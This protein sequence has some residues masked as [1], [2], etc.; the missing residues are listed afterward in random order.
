MIIT[1]VCPKNQGKSR[2]NPC[3]LWLTAI[4]LFSQKCPCAT[5]FGNVVCANDKSSAH[6]PVGLAILSIFILPISI[7]PLIIVV[8]ASKPSFTV[9]LAV[10]QYSESFFQ[11]YRLTL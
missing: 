7:T 11:S 4:L 2:Y 8:N 1:E 3:F 10:F 5:F 6:I 9:I